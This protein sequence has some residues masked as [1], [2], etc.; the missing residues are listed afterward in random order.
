[1]NVIALLLAAALQFGQS[2]T[3]ELH[4]R[5]TD[6][7]GLGV[8]S[9]VELVSESNQVKE[10]LET[11]EAGTLVARRLPF[12][13]YRLAISRAGFETFTGLVDI[14]SP[15]PTEFHV[16][17]SLAPVQAQVS[18]SADETLLDP[19]RSGTINRIGAD[20]LLR[21]VSALPGRTVPDLV[22]TQPGWLL[23]ANG[24]LHPRGSEYQVQYV[25]DGLPLTDN[26][27]P[28][29]AP[30]IGADDVRAMNIL[31]AG[32]PAE[33]GRKLGGV[34]EITTAGEARQGLHSSV[35]ASVG[36]FATAGGYATTQYG[37][38]RGTFG[39]SAN[40]ARTDRYLDPPVEENFTNRGASS[41]V[42]LHVEHGWS[43]AARAGAIVRTARSGFLVPNERLQQDAGQRQ[44]R[45][46]RETS[47]QFSY[48]HL[49]SSSVLVDGRAMVRDLSA[50]L[51]SNAFATPISARQDRGLR[52]TYVK[53]TVAAR[54]GA[55]DWKAG[56]DAVFGTIRES[57]GYTIADADRFAPGTTAALSFDDRARD[58]EQALFVQDRIQHGA[59]TVSAGLRWDRYR[60]LVAEDAISPRL[61]VAWSWP[62]ADVVVRG[63][64]DRAFQTP[65]AENLLLA[66]SAQLDGLAGEVVRIPLRPSRGHF[67]DIGASKRVGTLRVD[68]THFVRRM[69]EFA[70]DDVLLNTG[71]SFPI[72]FERA[73]IHG[74][75][76]KLEVPRWRAVS[77]SISYGHMKG[78]GFLPITGGLLLG[79]EAADALASTD[80]FPIS[81]DQRHTVRGRVSYQVSRRAWVAL[82]AAYGSGL[83]VEF[84]GDLD[85]AVEQYGSRTLD[86]VDFE[87][88]RLRP[89]ATLDASVGLSLLQRQSQRVRVQ[90]DV[91]NLTDRF[92][93][94]NFAGLFSGTALGA[95]RAFAVRAQF[96]F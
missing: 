50:G 28:S 89:A 3:G 60:L 38:A 39:V 92:N 25:V 63:S 4:L 72:A 48:Q 77:G 68:V 5:V 7:S 10:S 73:R 41:D 78:T 57:F 82:G 75:E 1:M 18:V 86:R 66:S 8:Q 84:E 21:R 35:V 76:V 94:I 51:W 70:D 43:D 59:W 34:I 33:Y 22:N 80:R 15:L 65:A 6:P 23:E 81:Q 95:P 19:Q 69:S 40:T 56:F 58:R 53:G 27:S 32:Y 17:L 96:E 74:T 12:G 67:F 71:V 47:G 13:R 93:V 54:R 42:A 55:H 31:T 26:R 91:L 62:R 46:T 29:F 9:A 90:A 16:T 14:R 64:Y 11:G 37:W 49:L 87:A 52:E 79:E 24:I 83:P 36:S 20:T 61:G 88:K 45:D 30:E 44:D 2:S 85:E